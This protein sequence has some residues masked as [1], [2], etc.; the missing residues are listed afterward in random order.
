MAPIAERLFS[1]GAVAAPPTGHVRGVGGVHIYI[2]HLERAVSTAGLLLES[3]AYRQI[4]RW[5][6]IGCSPW[7]S[8]PRF[9]FCFCFGLVHLMGFFRIVFHY[10][11]FHLPLG[12][13]S[14]HLSPSHFI[15]PHTHST[16]PLESPCSLFTHHLLIHS[17][18]H[19][20]ILSCNLLFLSFTFFAITPT[21]FYSQIPQSMSLITSPP[22]WTP[23]MHPCS[24]HAICC[25]NPI[26]TPPQPPRRDLCLPCISCRLPHA[27]FTVAPVSVPGQ[28]VM[29]NINYLI[30]FLLY[31][32][33]VYPMFISSTGNTM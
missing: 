11:R 33:L 25:C 16:L 9:G 32:E 15:Q 21:L 18:T 10:N 31:T 3:L 24:S 22:T 23:S 5:Y 12:T 26:C 7:V 17:F 2:P 29:V 14:F 1:S 27:V 19:F 6:C 20:I 8:V 30:S 28:L 4:F 13:F